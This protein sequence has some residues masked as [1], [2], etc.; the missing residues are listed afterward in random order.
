MFLTYLG[1][2]IDRPGD[3]PTVTNQLYCPELLEYKIAE[4]YFCVIKQDKKIKMFTQI[5][6]R[7][8]LDAF[9][10]FYAG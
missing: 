4:F 5:M 9:S 7:A 10:V 2:K 1:A 8:V 6:E 3:L